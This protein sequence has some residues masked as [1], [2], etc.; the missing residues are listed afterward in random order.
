[1]ISSLTINDQS[2]TAVTLH[3]TSQRAVVSANGLLGISAPRRSTRDRPTGHGSVDE[4]RYT[5]EKLIEV[6]GDV[7]GAT[8]ELAYAEFRLVSDPMLATLDGAASLLKWTEGAAG[9]QLQRLVKLAGPVEPALTEAATVLRYQAIFAA[10]DP[11]AY[12]QTLQ[13]FTGAVVGSGGVCS[14]NNAG[15]RPTP[16]LL[17]I[18]GPS[19]GHITNAAVSINGVSFM[20]VTNGDIAAG[21]YLEVDTYAR[22]ATLVTI[23]GGARQ[24]RQDLV[25]SSTTTWQDLPKGTSTLTLTGTSTTTASRADVLLRAAYS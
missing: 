25:N 19:S 6:V 18:F 1:M 14:P 22:T 20:F 16:A 15:Y 2:G 11:R 12:S 3:E 9:L 17:R 21:T 8:Q 13:T 7:W 10:Q 23:A 4:S 24:L 5:G